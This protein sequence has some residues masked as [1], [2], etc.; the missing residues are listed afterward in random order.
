MIF[1]CELGLKDNYIGLYINFEY[2]YKI[3]IQAKWLKGLN[4]LKGISIITKILSKI[5]KISF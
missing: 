1:K 3:E 2:F 4:L 5:D